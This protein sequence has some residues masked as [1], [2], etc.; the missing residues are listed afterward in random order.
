MSD[1]E[2][3]N[4]RNAGSADQVSVDM[5]RTA[6]STLTN[7]CRNLIVVSTEGAKRWW[8]FGRSFNRGLVSAMALSTAHCTISSDKRSVSKRPDRFLNQSRMLMS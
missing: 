2:T 8:Q 4:A 5:R 3:K 6:G 7:P 1:G